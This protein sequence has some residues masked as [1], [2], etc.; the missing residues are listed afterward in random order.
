MYTA[1]VDNPSRSHIV[2]KWPE[3]E[4]RYQFNRGAERRRGNKRWRRRVGRRR[5]RRRRRHC[6]KEKKRN[7][8]VLGDGHQIGDGGGDIQSR[9]LVGQ[10]R[11]NT[12]LPNGS[13]C[14]PLNRTCD[15]TS[16]NYQHARFKSK[17]NEYQV[18]GDATWM[19]CTGSYKKILSYV[20]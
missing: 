13:P 15:N 16:R 14:Q 4:R 3:I 10:R 11:R 8:V 18:V 19:K 12:Q 9:W 6:L 20:Q 17:Q 7:G 5:R 2:A 1:S